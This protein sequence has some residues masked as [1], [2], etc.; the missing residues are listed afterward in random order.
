MQFSILKGEPKL[1][2]SD[3]SSVK[4]LSSLEVKKLWNIPLN[5]KEAKR[6][7]ATHSALSRIPRDI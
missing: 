3:D 6:N 4:K 5:T 7:F 2:C 1:S